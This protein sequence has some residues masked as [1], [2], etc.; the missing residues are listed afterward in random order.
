M[1]IR[2][3][4]IEFYRVMK[5]VG[6]LEQKLMNLKPGTLERENVEKELRE[7]RAEEKR[8]RSMMEGAKEK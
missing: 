6:E 7:N 5:R 4:A 1:S 3:L 8:L 2:M